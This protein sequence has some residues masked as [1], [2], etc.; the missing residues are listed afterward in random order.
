MTMLSSAR[1]CF[2]IVRDE[3]PHI[4][5]LIGAG[6]SKTAG[7][8][9]ASEMV[10]EIWGVDK[11]AKRLIEL[12][13]NQTGSYPA[14]VGKLSRTEYLKLFRHSLDAAKVNL[15]HLCIAELLAKK[16]VDRILT[17]NF[18]SLLIQACAI[19]GVHPAIYD[20][21]AIPRL[22]PD[23]D[24]E[25][26]A[27][28]Y[29]HGQ[30]YG[31]RMVNTDWEMKEHSSPVRDVIHQSIANRTV[32]VAGCSAAPDGVLKHLIDVHT[33]GHVIWVPRTESDAKDALAAFDKMSGTR[34]VLECYDSDDFFHELLRAMNLKRPRITHNLGA[35]SRQARKRVVDK[36][37]D[38]FPQTRA[39]RK[40]ATTE[41]VAPETPAVSWPKAPRSPFSSEGA[42]PPPSIG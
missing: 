31:L 19:S 30:S 6:C 23:L 41:P 5:L 12:P 33:T 29:L 15:A 1:I 3:R 8:P 9:L 21:V 42:G 20:C 7:I 38:W 37:P 11:Y 22:P 24:D 2:D 26:P 4:A 36:L 14:V 13:D 39:E 25:Q 32:I 35:F 17:T 16:V 28:Y 10:K 34:W 40:A 27:L 18:D